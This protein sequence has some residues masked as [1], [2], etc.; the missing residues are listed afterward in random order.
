MFL[1]L[2]LLQSAA[3]V[4]ALT[5]T[6]RSARLIESSGVAASRTHAG[7]LWTHNDS[8]DGPNLYATD[9][10]GTDRG[11]VRVPGAAA[12][13]WEDIALGPCPRR[14]G[15]CLYVADTGD[16]L[17]RRA[18]VTV[19]AVPEPD[20]PRTAADTQRVT[21]AALALSL[22]YPDGPHDV[23][24]LYVSARDTAVYL[25]SKGRGRDG[26]IRLYR[27]DRAAWDTRGVVRAEFVQTL[28]IVPDGAA[29]RLVTG[30]AVRADG[31]LVAIRTYSEVY[32]FSPG[33]GG[34]L[35]PADRPVCS[36]AELERLG[37]GIG[38]LDDSS[39]VLTSEA[40][41]FGPGTI[42]TVRCPR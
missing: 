18:R 38:F 29:G 28:P 1:P 21:A 31:G 19:Y 2:L 42:H 27:V 25:V 9:L 15:D 14:P 34:L 7:I 13:D 37:E 20:P 35:R 39:L 10:H 8:G 26:S 16:N 23:E 17:E 40:T 4:T 30:A 32:F 11:A 22:Y 5:G 36:I 12:V 41:L 24:A 3:T 6:F 33:P